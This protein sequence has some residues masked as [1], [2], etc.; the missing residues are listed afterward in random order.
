MLTFQIF[1][2]PL[3]SLSDVLGLEDT[4]LF[5][6]PRLLAASHDYLLPPM[7]TCCLPRLPA[8]SHDYLLLPTTICCVPRLSAASPWS[9][10]YPLGDSSTRFLLSTSRFN[11]CIG[12]GGARGT[13]CVNLAVSAKIT[14]LTVALSFACAVTQR[15]KYPVTR[16]TREMKL[17]DYPIR[18]HERKADERQGLNHI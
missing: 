11:F 6:P 14:N 17:N 8:A 1:A 7:T 5:V 15:R 4:P 16:E 18:H 3:P 10:P 9:Q 2:A 13:V 12:C